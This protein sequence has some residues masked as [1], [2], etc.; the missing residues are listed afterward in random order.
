MQ[1]WQEEWERKV[2]EFLRCI[3][4]FRK[5]SGVWMALASR[6][7]STSTNLSDLAIQG[8]VAYAKKTANRFHQLHSTACSILG[9][10]GAGYKALNDDNVIA[11]IKADRAEMEETVRR[12]IDSAITQAATEAPNHRMS[13][14]SMLS[15]ISLLIKVQGAN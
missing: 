6:S 8:K 15:L 10:A 11:F 3:R 14:L 9:Q 2:I 13:S 5:M 1:R 7:Q 4:Y 12:A